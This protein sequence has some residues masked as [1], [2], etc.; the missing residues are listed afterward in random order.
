MSARILGAPS[1]LHAADA[2][3]HHKCNTAFHRDAHRTSDV[4]SKYAVNDQGFAETVTVVNSDR[5]KIWNSLD[6]E[7]ID[8]DNGGLIMSR[9]SLIEK[10]IQHIG[11][12]II[13]LYSPGMATLLVFR[14][15]IPANLKL[16]ND[17]E[18]D[19]MDEC[20]R[21]VGKQIMK[22][23]KE[24]K[25]DFKSYCKHINREMTSESASETLTKLLSAVTPKF[26]NSLQPI[27]VGNIVCSVVTC[28]P[29]PLQI[30]LGMLLGDHKML[31]TELYNYNMCCSYDEVRRFK[32]LA[33]VQSSKA[34]LFAGLRDATIGGLVQIIIDNFDAMISSQNCRLECHYMAMLAGQWKAD[35][36]RSDGLD[37]TIPHLSKEEMN[38]PILARHR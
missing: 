11:D 4:D 24:M 2:R 13:S 19:D 29:T 12:E 33:A 36:D 21:K 1:D 18:N 37:M 30:A 5:S 7:A 22:E 6:V 16:V 26:Q 20:V 8:R 15:H 27:M 3:Y 9:R 23:S 14:K 34:R 10:V 32:R 38:Q 35:I 25:R 28:Q 17:D 31:I